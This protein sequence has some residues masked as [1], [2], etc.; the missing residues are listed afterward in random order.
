MQSPVCSVSETRKCSSSP[1]M[2]LREGVQSPARVCTA[3]VSSAASA[4]SGSRTAS[5]HTARQAIRRFML[6]PPFPTENRG[7]C[8]FG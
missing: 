1:G 3:A 2:A 8:F 6:F 5:R 4:R 7:K